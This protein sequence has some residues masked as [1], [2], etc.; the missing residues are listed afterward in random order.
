MTRN[1]GRGKQTT[2]RKH[3]ERFRFQPGWLSLTARVTDYNRSS[4]QEFAAVYLHMISSTEPSQ[5]YHKPDGFLH[6]TMY[7]QNSFDSS[8]FASLLCIIHL[9]ALQTRLSCRQLTCAM[10]SSCLIVH[11]AVHTTGVT[12]SGTQT[13]TKFVQKHRHGCTSWNS[14]S[15]LGMVQNNCAISIYKQQQLFYGP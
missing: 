2:Y 15:K 6:R 10:H 12:W 8:I 1:K 3:C 13:L 11:G 7:S 5:Q 4:P 9:S 14:W